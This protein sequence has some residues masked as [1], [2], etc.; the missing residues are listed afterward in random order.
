M[1]YLAEW[2]NQLLRLEIFHNFNAVFITNRAHLNVVIVF[3]LLRQWYFIGMIIILVSWAL[4]NV[5]TR[6]HRMFF[7]F[8]FAQSG[9][10]F[11]H[12]QNVNNM[13]D[14]FW[15]YFRNILLIDWLE[16]IVTSFSYLSKRIFEQNHFETIKFVAELFIWI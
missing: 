6:T 12:G 8:H 10:F 2:L 11:A 3:Y 5:S 1:E 14:I 7:V 4:L 15:F 16:W 13:Y 9:I